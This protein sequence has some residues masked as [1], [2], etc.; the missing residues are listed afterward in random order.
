MAKFIA[1]VLIAAAVVVNGGHLQADLL[2]YDDIGV[3][4]GDTPHGFIEGGY[5]FS[6][7]IYVTDATHTGGGTAISG[8]FVAF[9][10]TPFTI[11]QVGGGLFNFVDTYI[12]PWFYPNY[13]GRDVTITGYRNNVVVG[14]ASFSGITTW[15]DLVAN[16]Q[17]VDKVDFSAGGYSFIDNTTITAASAVPEPSTL[18]LL[19][20]GGIGLAL[21]AYR[22]RRL[23]AA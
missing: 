14:T 23:A 20:L 16:L 22:R 13:G 8:N 21:G 19:G 6:D 12:E 10:S 3:P 2:T 11:T 9:A 4:N 15:T 1:L 18:T 7:S 5:Q 17:N